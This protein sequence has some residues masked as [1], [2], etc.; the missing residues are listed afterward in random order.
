M[1]RNA[2]DGNVRQNLR[3]AID[4]IPEACVC[5]GLEIFGEIAGAVA[6]RRSGCVFEFTALNHVTSPGERGYCAAIFDA[7]VAAGVIEM[8]VRVDDEIDFVWLDTVLGER[9]DKRVAFLHGVNGARLRLPLR[10]V[11]SFDHDGLA[12]RTD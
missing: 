9:I 6:F 12:M 4:E 10:A 2:N 5:D 3:V 11:A 1:A 7:S 8:K